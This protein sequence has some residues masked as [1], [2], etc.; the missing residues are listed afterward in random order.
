MTCRCA[1]RSGGRWRP[2]QTG[3]LYGN[4]YTWGLEDDDSKEHFDTPAVDSI[5]LMA[6]FFGARA[7]QDLVTDLDNHFLTR[8]AGSPDRGG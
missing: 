3:R 6:E 5:A 7:W 8:W 4:K 2:G 1:G